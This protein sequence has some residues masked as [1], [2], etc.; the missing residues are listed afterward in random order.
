MGQECNQLNNKV[1]VNEIE[2]QLKRINDII[3]KNELEESYNDNSKENIS[4][5]SNPHRQNQRL[6]R[7]NNMINKIENEVKKVPL[8]KKDNLYSE[9][10]ILKKENSELINKN[11]ELKDKNNELKKENS[12]LVNE[13]KKLMDENDKLKDEVKSLKNENNNLKNENNNLK[14]ENNNLKNENNNLKNENNN[15]KNKN[16]K[17][18]NKIELNKENDNNNL[19]NKYENNYFNKN[20]FDLKHKVLE[21]QKEMRKKVDNY[22]GNFKQNS[23]NINNM[24][25]KKNNNYIINANKIVNI[26]LNQLLEDMCIYG[27]IIKEEIKMKKYTNN[28]II[29]IDEALKS[30][31]NDQGLFALGL[32]AY[33]LENNGIKTIIESQF[34][35]E[36]EDEAATSLQFISNGLIFRRKYDLH[37]EFGRKRNEELLKNKNEYEKF[38]YKI[39]LKL[40]KDFNIPMDEIIVTYPQKG[41]FHVQVIF[42]SDKFNDLD[43][44]EFKRKF[45]NDQEF[46]ELSNLKEIHTGVIMSAC[47]LSKGQLDP[48][49]NRCDGWAIG[50]KRGNKEYIP[51]I[52]WTGIGLKV[53][54]KYENNKWIGMSNDPDEWCVAY[55]GV[56]Y[57]QDS[58]TVK[59]ITGLIYKG[60]FKPGNRQVHEDCPDKFH[61]GKNVGVG[62]YCTPNI[63]IA[64]DYA[65]VS[66]INGKNY[67]TVLMVRVKPDSI[68][69]CNNYKHQ[70]AKDY[71][72]VNGNNDEIRP[73]RILYKS[74]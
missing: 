68:R 56:G 1:S 15:L 63:K 47:K 30:E 2:N 62:V 13:K 29:K 16:N 20:I 49:G 31:K 66:N 71:W 27:N 4:E 46:D 28:N 12:Q 9:N 60:N 72:V 44:D 35:K 37:F 55:H 45:Q 22:S 32:L 26:K 65:G 70:D 64:E 6:S 25:N 10:N 33:N 19:N 42:Q 59:K 23:I 17:L 74:V 24:D 51:P 50:E 11:N 67:K 54:D 40:S 5:E 3:K 53:I 34:N 57:S 43:L 38:K 39:K 36:D 52:G 8:L 58:N 61:S 73:Y 69:C 14:N 41:S 48:R 18:M 7:I 21:N